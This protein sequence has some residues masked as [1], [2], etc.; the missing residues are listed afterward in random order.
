HVEMETRRLVEEERMSASEARRRALIVFGGLDAHR[1]AMRDGRGARWFGDLGADV[2]Y[3][4][5]AMRRAPGFAIAVA[6]T[7]GVGIG[8]NGIVFGYADS[9]LFR[10]VP[11]REPDRLVSMFV[12]GGKS[13]Q[14]DQ[15]GYQDYAD[16]RDK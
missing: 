5:R 14:P 6:L 15:V 4:V 3:A 7:L 11:A 13:K 2:R 10:R 12:I 16:Y 8:V 1:E 9:L